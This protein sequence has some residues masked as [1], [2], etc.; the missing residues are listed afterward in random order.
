V[1]LAAA[2]SQ[3]VALAEVGNQKF[4]IKLCHPMFAKGSSLKIL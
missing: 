3:V 2:D 4:D 1:A